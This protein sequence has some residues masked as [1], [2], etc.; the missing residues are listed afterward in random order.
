MRGCVILKA[1]IYAKAGIYLRVIFETENI[2]NRKA[3]EM[4]EL[5][6]DAKVLQ[7][8]QIVSSQFVCP[9]P[10]VWDLKK[11]TLLVSVVRGSVVCL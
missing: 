8:P 6:L 4:L 7:M 9:S 11:K 1:K 3:G 10:K 5:K 2:D